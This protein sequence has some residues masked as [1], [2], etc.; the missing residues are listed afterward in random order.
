MAKIDRIKL[1]DKSQ[2]ELIRLIHDLERKNNS[3][4][5]Q[6]SEHKAK[7]NELFDR[8]E[9]CQ[10]ESA[11]LK[12][13]NDVK[14]GNA[15]NINATWIDKI[16]FVLKSTGRPMRSSEI[17]EV[18]VKNDKTFRTLTDPQK[19]LSA[20]LTRAMK[21]GRVIGVKQKGMNGYV[22]ELPKKPIKKE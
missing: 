2:T 22:W 19:G 16:V 11:E 9:K 17:I 12:H 13:V 3:L 6:L 4:Q 7:I 14:L 5:S 15:F 18:L 1:L 20:H 8:L 21:F 10:I